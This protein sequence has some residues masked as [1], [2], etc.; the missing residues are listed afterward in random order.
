VWRG[1]TKLRGRFRAC[2]HVGGRDAELDDLIA[3]I[4]S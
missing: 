1:M 3:V 2:A 4:Q